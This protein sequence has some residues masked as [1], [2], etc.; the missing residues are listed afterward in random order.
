M[1]FQKHV[2]GEILKI[3]KSC[4]K[5]GPI[6]GQACMIQPRQVLGSTNAF[7]TDLSKVSRLTL[8][9][10]T[11]EIYGHNYWHVASLHHIAT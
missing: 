10:T 6:L 2:I 8:I 1:A 3:Y 9:P 5:S 7:S 11:N 4:L